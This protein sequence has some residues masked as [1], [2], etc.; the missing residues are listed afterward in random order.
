MGLCEAAL[1]LIGIAG[2]DDQEHHTR[3]YERANKGDETLR[4]QP[5]Q[6]PI[7]PQ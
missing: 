5:L 1:D 2:A 4:V 7:R 3:A 6:L